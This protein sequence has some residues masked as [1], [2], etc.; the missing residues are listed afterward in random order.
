VTDRT[1]PRTARAALIYVAPAAVYV[2]Y[3][4]VMGSIRNG[5]PPMG[6]SDKTAHFAA[7]GLMVPLFARALGYLHPDGGRTRAV[8]VATAL[9]SFAGALLEVWQSFIPYR[10]ADVRDWIADTI[11]AVLAGCLLLVLGSATPRRDAGLGSGAR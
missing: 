9:S 1:P 2:L 7:F 5:N 11:G 6:V 8:L 3:I 4:F 10:S